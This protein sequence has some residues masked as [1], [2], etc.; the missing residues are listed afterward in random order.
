MQQSQQHRHTKLK[1]GI[2]VLV[3]IPLSAFFSALQRQRPPGKMLVT[4]RMVKQQA[5][6][7]EQRWENP[8]ANHSSS[9]M[10]VLSRLETLVRS[11]QETGAVLKHMVQTLGHPSV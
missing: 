4:P 8:K 3:L 10:H 9:P 6:I 5:S 1:I 7:F 11:M 2:F